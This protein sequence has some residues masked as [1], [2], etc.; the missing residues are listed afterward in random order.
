MNKLIIVVVFG[1]LVVLAL[2][3]LNK[4]KKI[5]YE[6]HPSKLGTWKTVADNNSIV[7]FISGYPDRSDIW[8][9]KFIGKKTKYDIMKTSIVREIS[10]FA[11]VIIYDRPGTITIVD[12][13]ETPAA[14]PI[15]LKSRSYNHS[16][17][18]SAS[19]HVS[20]LVILLDQLV[21]E[22]LISNEPITIVAHS[23][24]GLCARLFDLENP[25]RV[26]N[27]LLLDITNE[28]LL[29]SWTKEEINAYLYST[30]YLPSKV[31]PLY[32]NF[33]VI[34]FLKSFQELEN[35]RNNKKGFYK[36][37]STKC[38]L[39]ASSIAPKVEDMVNIGEWPKEV[40][41]IPNFSQSVL[42]GVQKSYSLMRE[43]SLHHMSIIIVKDSSHYIQRD[44]PWEVIKWIKKLIH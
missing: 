11:K 34:D 39:L 22:K 16:Q 15:I 40:L 23:A 42:S 26:K 7:L 18:V 32:P 30:R 41:T 19:D 12:N 27:M 9:E 2:W 38:V 5:Y 4:R 1:G 35:A 29:K 37:S 43:D 10:K 21:N 44:A 3:L 13:K 17:P 6:I 31:T 25:N 28:Y 33:E 24:G 8:R 20:D 14:D 36:G